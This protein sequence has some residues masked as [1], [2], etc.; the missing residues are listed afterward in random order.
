MAKFLLDGQALDD[1]ANK[2]QQLQELFGVIQSENS[3]TMRACVM[4][5]IGNDIAERAA[6]ELG[7]LR[8]VSR[9]EV[10]A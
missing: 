2:L 7:E 5:D 1:L 6:I 9:A 8:S 10:S 4:C 3:I